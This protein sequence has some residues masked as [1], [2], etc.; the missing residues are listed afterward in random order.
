VTAGQVG[1]LPADLL[2]RARHQQ[3]RQHTVV[4]HG[5]GRAV[6]PVGQR[7]RGARGGVTVDAEHGRRD[8]WA[9]AE[10]VH[11]VGPDR[12]CLRGSE[13]HVRVDGRGDRSAEAGPLERRGGHG[14]GHATEEHA[15]GHVGG[16]PV[17]LLASSADEDR[18]VRGADGVRRHVV[19]VGRRARQH[20][21]GDANGIGHPRKWLPPLDRH[22]TERETTTSTKAEH[23]PTRCQLRQRAERRRRRRGVT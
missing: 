14:Q 15:V 17:E 12:L 2:D 19:A 3:G 20:G 9:V 6:V 7:R 10:R 16:Q 8:R 21:T 18:H 13:G 22:G 11:E 5:S 4:D 1:Q 23:H